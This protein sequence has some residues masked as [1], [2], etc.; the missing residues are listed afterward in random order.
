MSTA[1][2]SWQKGLPLLIGNH[3]RHNVLARQSLHNLVGPRAMRHEAHAARGLLAHRGLGL[4]R[5]LEL[6]ETVSA[7]AIA[8][9]ALNRGLFIITAGHN[10][11]RF[12]PP[13][14][15]SKEEIDEGIAIL[16]ECLDGLN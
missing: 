3:T 11:L 13:L 5:G 6:D 2:C 15:I 12:L 10:V 8:T 1:A 14:I 4:I 16:E 7:G 9:A